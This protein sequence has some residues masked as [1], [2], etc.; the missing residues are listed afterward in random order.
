MISS[1]WHTDLVF[2]ALRSV[3]LG[4][5]IAYLFWSGASRRLHRI[6]GWRMMVSG[7][8]LVFVGTLL[9]ITDN[10][11]SLNRFIVVGDTVVEA[12]L[13][14]EVGYLM[15]VLLIYLGYRKWLPGV[16]GRTKELEAEIARREAAEVERRKA[17]ALLLQSQRL[18]TVGRLASGVAHDFNN[19]LTAIVGHGWLVAR[20]V[21]RGTLEPAKIERSIG[22]IQ[23]AARR[24]EALAD[25][26]LI[27]SREQQ[28][29]P[30]FLD[31]RIVTEDLQ[32]ML[33][34]LLPAGISLA[35]DVDEKVRRIFADLHQFEQVVMNL[36]VNARDA[37][38]DGGAIRIAAADVRLTQEE[39]HPEV[40]AGDFVRFSVQDTGSGISPEI[41]E[42]IFEPFF[43]TKS[44]GRGTGLGMSTVRSIVEKFDGFITVE[45]AVGEGT[46]F[47]VFLPG[48]EA[49]TTP[50]PEAEAAKSTAGAGELL[51]VCE[52]DPNVR[53]LLEQV[54]EE[55]GYEVVAT[56]HALAAEAAFHASE[57]AF[58]LL[59]TGLVI[60]G[61]KTGPELAQAL[62]AQQPR[63]RV[64]FITGYGAEALESMGVDGG[65]GRVVVS[66]PFSIPDLLL[67]VR[68][69]LDDEPA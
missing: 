13:E 52:D 60:P 38:S 63:L 6:P 45:S 69:A 65:E 55:A 28:D 35:V 18:E 39:C 26:L 4:A 51:L 24:G 25:Q 67:A 17:E 15:G 43:T 14:K 54:F 64:V 40:A 3:V 47:S 10:F 59:V 61:G 37:M 50:I 46:T 9:D 68:E 48:M 5:I 42:R 62:I 21:R 58:D 2:E 23:L 8:G 34:R 53:A 19:I 49:P 66:K 31:P 36:V 33:E 32:S 56:S 57:R 11:A 27:F 44:A 1:N 29:E 22:Q 41:L 7:F 16:E 30:V 12:F 20:D